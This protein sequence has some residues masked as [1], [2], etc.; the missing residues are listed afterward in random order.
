MLLFAS[1]AK[2][3]N[4]IH[5]LDQVRLIFIEYLTVLYEPKVVFV[6]KLL[7]TF[8]PSSPFMIEKQMFVY[9]PSS[10]EIGRA[11]V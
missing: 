4:T 7:A 9:S 2:Y 6:M 8:M 1:V 5:C 3:R 10:V 11:H